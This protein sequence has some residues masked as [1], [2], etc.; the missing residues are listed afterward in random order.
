MKQF[1]KYKWYLAGVFLLLCVY[2]FMLPKELFHDPYSTVLEDSAGELLSASI[3]ADGQWRFPETVAVPEKFSESLIRYE[4]KRF[5]NHPGVD[6]LSLG[7]AF[8]QN[9][10]KGS[11]VSG[12]STI[13][14]Q[15]IRLSRKGKPR[16][17][18][19]KIIEIA[20]ATR[21][22]LRYSKDEILSLYAS[23]AP[24]GGNVVGLEAACWRYFGRDP[25][26]LSWGE[27]A[28]LAVL[29]NAPSL[30]H[31]GKNRGRLKA[32]R[33]LLLEK[34]KDAGTIDAF[35]CALSKDEPIPEEP[36]PLPRYARHLLSRTSQEGYAERKVQTTIQSSLQLRVEQIVNDHH[37]RLKGNQIFNAAAMVV[38][39]STGNV[40]AYVGNTDVKEK[41]NYSEAVDVIT[42]PQKYRKY[43]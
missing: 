25:Q 38:E 4:D 9:I 23:H 21:L 27:A 26:E 7:R 18:L 14:M 19:Q 3:A 13:S 16:T 5:R 15:V 35:T 6:V 11:V 12:G 36:Q 43:P 34:L 10:K 1:I 24:F 30:I 29:P 39:V 22:E 40:L 20:L 17:V 28:L 32:K 33:D 8:I 41:G 2:Y 42:A 37:Q 31:P